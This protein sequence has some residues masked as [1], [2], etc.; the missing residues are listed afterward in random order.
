MKVKNKVALY[1]RKEYV[2][3]KYNNM[4][5]YKL[6][7][8]G[9]CV[10]KTYEL[11]L[12]LHEMLSIINARRKNNIN[13]TSDLYV[14]QI[15]EDDRKSFDYVEEKYVFNDDTNMLRYENDHDYVPDDLEVSARFFDALDGYGMPNSANRTINTTVQPTKQ[16]IKIV[17]NISKNILNNFDAKS[18]IPK[19]I[20][21]DNEDGNKLSHEERYKLRCIEIDESNEIDKELYGDNREREE[22]SPEEIKKQIEE[23]EKMRE[24]E[25]ERL[26]KI[27][28]KHEEEQKNLVEFVCEENYKKKKDF[29]QR[30][31]EEE[32]VRKY[33]GA[34]ATY[35]RFCSINEISP[36]NPVIEMK[37]VS[38][39]FMNEFKILRFMYGNDMMNKENTY[40]NYCELLNYLRL[41]DK[42]EVERTKLIDELEADINKHI[43]SLE[44]IL[45][46]LDDIPDIAD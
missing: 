34:V 26:E 42:E 32:R 21:S 38:D 40:A 31:A 3:D 5:I 9:R 23:L 35:E 7:E 27:K 28:Q 43:P 11:K 8:C 41:E 44:E 10:Y 30:E 46:K 37:Y 1:E 22:M 2:N 18:K 39:L 33:E 17:D 24:E 25:E 4:S 6:Y 45:N 36:N 19:V 12:A 14:E 16:Q 29:L 15:Y 20:L 13:I